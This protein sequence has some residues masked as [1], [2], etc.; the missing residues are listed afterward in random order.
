MSSGV[1]ERSVNHYTRAQSLSHYTEWQLAASFPC[2]Q[3][4]LAVKNNAIYHWRIINPFWIIDPTK[5]K[6][7]LGFS[8]HYTFLPPFWRSMYYRHQN[9][10]ELILLACESTRWS[11]MDLFVPLSCEFNLFNFLT[12]WGCVS[13]PRSTT[14]GGWKLLI[15]AKSEIK[16]LQ[17]L[18]FKQSFNSQ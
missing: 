1:T 3:T 9:L 14:S 5:L 10:T 2:F 18:M 16:H 15:F 6:R 17:I 11:E 7:L 12:I 4:N 13:L 8:F